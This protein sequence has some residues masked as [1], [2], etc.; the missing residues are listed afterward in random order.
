MSV[1]LKNRILQILTPT[2]ELSHVHY[3]V[4]AIIKNQASGFV[5]NYG[6][7]YEKPELNFDKLMQLSEI[8]GTREIDVDDYSEGGCETCDYGSDYGHEIQIYNPTKNVEE[9]KEL[10]GNWNV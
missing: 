7:M 5:I 8:F 6:Q 9:M 2:D 3:S 1:E 10:I 4:R